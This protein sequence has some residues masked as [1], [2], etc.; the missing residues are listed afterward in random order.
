MRKAQGSC[1]IKTIFDFTLTAVGTVVISPLLIYVA[2]RIK[3]EDPGPVFFAHTRIGKNGQ[4]FKCY[5]FLSMYVENDEIL[6]RYL[7]ANPEKKRMGII[8]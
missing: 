1:L 6:N 2:Y 3:K 5:K 7:T 8:S 4:P